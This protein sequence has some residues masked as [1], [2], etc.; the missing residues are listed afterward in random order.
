MPWQECSPMDL[1]LQFVRDWQSG[2]W[3]MTELC[4]DYQISRKTGYKCVASRGER[5]GRPR[6]SIA[7]SAPPSARHGEGAGRAAD[8]AATTPPTVGRAEAVDG[9]G[10][11]GAGGGLAETDH[12]V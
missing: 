1:R 6:G 10:P 9:R 7:A 3:T 8:R 11:A 4:A 12:R 5:P 2:A